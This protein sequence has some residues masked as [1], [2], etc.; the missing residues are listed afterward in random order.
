MENARPE[1]EIG[2]GIA[3]AAPNFTSHRKMQWHTQDL[4]WHG[5]MS[6]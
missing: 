3:G 5:K 6:G 1:M 4:A 2:N